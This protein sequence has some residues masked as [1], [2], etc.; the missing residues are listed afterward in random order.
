M[1]KYDVK[2]EAMELAK[3]LRYNPELS[4]EERLNDLAIVL[5]LRLQAAYTAG[6][7]V[8]TS[9]ESVDVLDASRG[10]SQ[11]VPPSVPFRAGGLKN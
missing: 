6:Q 5:E 3:T 7:D 2:K 8:A 9:T 11:V 1:K 4:S 10:S